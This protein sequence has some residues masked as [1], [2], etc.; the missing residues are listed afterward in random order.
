MRRLRLVAAAGIAVLAAGQN[1]NAAGGFATRELNPMLQPLFLPSL[2]PLRSDDGWRID[3][4]VF[5]TNTF[6][7]KQ[8]GDES[9]II[10]VENYRYELDI[11]HRRNNWLTQL[12]IPL[13]AN[14]SGDLDG[15]IEDWHDFFGFPQGKR[16]EFPADKINVQYTRDG[17]VAYSQTEP[18]S[19]VGD[20]AV[21]VGYQDAGGT[22]YFA[23]IELPTGSATEFTGNEAVDLAFWITRDVRINA[24]VNAFGMLGISFPGDD[25][26]LKGLIVDRVWVAQL[27]LDYRFYDDF[28]ATV[29]LDMHSETIEDSKFRAFRESYQI[30]LGLG[31]LKLFENH[32]L[33]L[34]FSEDILVRSA[35]DITFGLRLAREF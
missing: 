33:D 11:S 21:S 14:R 4:S 3:H 18:S 31:Y 9:L 35:P 16:D 29:Q 7:Q 26:N 15:L 19:G 1:L 24:E 23:G 17:V 2:L 32:R 5:V 27:G 10:D 22:A 6:Q 34:F 25:G 12:N 28:V 8:R 20:I 13:V 30:Q